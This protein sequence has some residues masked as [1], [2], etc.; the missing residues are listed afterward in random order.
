MNLSPGGLCVILLQGVGEQKVP[1]WYERVTGIIAIPAAMVG[2]AYSYLLI[3]KTQ[4]ES[5]KLE[6][7]I[8]EKSTNPKLTS[9]TE[10]LSRVVSESAQAVTQ[11]LVNRRYSVLVLRYVVLELTL[12]IY[13]GLTAPL[14][15]VGSLFGGVLLAAL[16]SLR[17]LTHARFE[18]RALTIFP[19]AVAGTESIA[20]VLVSIGYWAI[21]FALGWPLFKEV[22]A[23]LGID[24]KEY[25]PRAMLHTIRRLKKRQ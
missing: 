4:L 23:V 22:N 24:L 16:Q 2:C 25:S 18:P 11:T 12:S 5:R 21:F 17:I 20:S 1:Q 13:S 7:E 9:A 15:W 6:I 10:D 14:N 8:S 3:R 19:L